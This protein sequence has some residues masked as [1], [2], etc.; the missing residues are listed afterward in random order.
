M[1][2]SFIVPGTGLEPAR[3]SA[4]APQTYV[5]TSST[6]RAGRQIYTFAGF[7]DL[8]FTTIWKLSLEGQPLLFFIKY[9]KNLFNI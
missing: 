1:P 3:L 8:D 9:I 5:S 2:V 4:Y 6:T 7:Q